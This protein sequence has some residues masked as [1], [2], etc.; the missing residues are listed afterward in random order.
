VKYPGPGLREAARHI[1]AEWREGDLIVASRRRNR[2]AAFEYYGGVTREPAEKPAGV[3][4]PGAI[5]PWLIQTT[6][7]ARRIWAVYYDDEDSEFARVLE[8]HSERFA[9]AEPFMR[10]GETGVR[11]FEVIDSASLSLTIEE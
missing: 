1:A 10:V 8:E 11:L 7:G 2:S 6:A 3:D 9:P 4:T 5:L